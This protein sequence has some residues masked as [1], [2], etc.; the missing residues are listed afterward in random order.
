MDLDLHKRHSSSEGKQGKFSRFLFGF[1]FKSDT[2]TIAPKFL[3]I[4][5]LWDENNK[6][7]D[8]DAFIITVDGTHCHI[9]E[10][11][12][13]PSAQ[14]YSN[15]YNKAGL[16]YKLAIALHSNNLVG[17]NGPFPAGQNDLQIWR[18]EGGLKGKIPANKQAI[19]D[20]GYRGE[21]QI[22]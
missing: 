21:P 17:I 15:K 12:M 1:V 13:Q 10:P 19:A 14:L 18:K 9:N 3:Q 4:V 11:R 6:H 8:D 22:S 20:Q 16:A 2:L 7:Q 5:W